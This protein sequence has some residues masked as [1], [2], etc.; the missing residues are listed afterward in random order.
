MRIAVLS[1]IHSNLEALDSVLKR[2]EEDGIDEILCAGDLV[3]YGADPNECV[4]RVK[5]CSSAVVC[6]NHD[7][8]A[9]GLADPDFFNSVA[10][11]AVVWT[12]EQLTESNKNYLIKLPLSLS[13]DGFRLVHA[14]PSRPEKW[15]YIFHTVE[16][17]RELHSFGEKVCFIGHSHKPI[18]FRSDGID[19][20]MSS[21]ESIEFKDNERYLVNVGSVGQPRDGDPRACFAVYSP[22]EGWVKLIRIAYDIQAAQKKMALAGLPRVL[23][24]RLSYGQ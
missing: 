6:G 8:A 14:S 12:G 11:N 16:A 2:I 1:D 20:R 13:R 4:E 15:N 17:N 5:K 22:D 3:G 19:C 10:R 21:E 9:V 18:F 23:A 24:E 7:Y